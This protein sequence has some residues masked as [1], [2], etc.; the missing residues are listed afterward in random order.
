MDVE[1]TKIY[2]TLTYGS[3]AKVSACS[4]IAISFPVFST[5][6]TQPLHEYT[7]ERAWKDIHDR[8]QAPSYLSRVDHNWKIRA[9]EQ[10]SENTLL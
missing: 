10:T 1:H 8:L 3:F 4:S 6:Y 2:P 9:R 7:G 5:N